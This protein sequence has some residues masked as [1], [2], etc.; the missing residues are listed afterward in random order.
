MISSVFR[1]HRT[2]VLAV[3]LVIA[4]A[5]GAVGAVAAM[6]ASTDRTALADGRTIDGTFCAG[7]CI[8]VTTSDGQ[9]A[10]SPEGLSLRPGT[11]WLTVT[12]TSSRHDFVLRSCPG[13]TSPCDQSSNGDE[14]PLTTISEGSTVAPV[15]ETL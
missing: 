15:V 10:Q 3:A 11:Y 1:T 7:L 12:D 6:A 13:S 9:M 8:S 2:A 4:S 5:V 14:L